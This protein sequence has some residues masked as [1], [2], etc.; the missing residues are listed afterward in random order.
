MGLLARRLGIQALSMEDPAQPLL[1]PSA[2]YE[3]LGLGRSDAGVLINEQQAM[4][5]STQHTCVKVISE[6]LA[7]CAHEIFQEMPDGSMRLAREHRLWKLLHDQPNATMT[8]VVFW[9]AYLACVAGWGNAY[10]WIKRDRA[11][12]A[13]SLHLLRPGLTSPVRVAGELMYATTQTANGQTAFIDPAN[14]LH[15]MGMSF[16]GFVGLGPIMCV[17]AYGLANAAEKFGAQ[18]FGNGARATGVYTYPGVLEEEAQ[19]NIAKSVQEMATGNNALR[20]VILEE[21]MQWQQISIAPNEAQMLETRRYQRTE[22]AGLNRVPLH[23]VGDPKAANTKLE[24]EGTDYVR[25]CLRPYAVKIEQEVGSKLLA[26]PFSMEHRLRD[27]ERGNFESQTKGLQTLRNIGVYSTNDCLRELRRN[28]ISVAEGGEVRTVQGAMIPLDSLLHVEVEGGLANEE[29]A[30]Q[31]AATGTARGRQLVASYRGL[32]RDAVGR[33]INRAGD[34]EFARKAFQPVI[35]SMCQALVAM[36]FGGDLSKRDLELIGK[37]ASAI[38]DSASSWQG[39]DAS[40][41]AL[42]WTETTYEVLAK[43]IL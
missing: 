29:P 23:L 21:G 32:F 24:E 16:D 26:A 42:R 1:P 13:V 34:A 15:V 7:S 37:Q 2:M 5:I 6:D 30:S 41:I 17:N 9:G 33:V 4:R 35:S 39:A 25:Y 18:F 3:S 38:A 31:Q 14:T 8:A 10:A 19:Q 20:P 40:A 36:R 27:L 28:P 11:A 43:E 22:I 12:R